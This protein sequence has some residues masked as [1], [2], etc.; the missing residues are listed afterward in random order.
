MKPRVYISCPLTKI[1]NPEAAKANYERAAKVCA[2]EGLVPILPHMKND[3]IRHAHV[4]PRQV[5][6]SDM[7]DLTSASLIVAFVGQPSHGVGAEIM[8]ATIHNIPI[9]L[10]AEQD[11]VISRFILGSPMVVSLIRYND[12]DRALQDLRSKL[13]L[14]LPAALSGGVA[15]F[16][17]N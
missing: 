10:L 9:I 6:E 4:S 14:L 13:R 12:F 15:M 2:G 8:L 5:F 11:S 7:A 3:P 16:I 1:S 17:S